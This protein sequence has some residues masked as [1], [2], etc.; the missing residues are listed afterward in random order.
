M[1]LT[2]T[3][4][5][6]E[7]PSYHKEKVTQEASGRVYIGKGSTVMN[8]WVKGHSLQRVGKSEQRDQAPSQRVQNKEP[9]GWP[10]EPNEP[11]REGRGQPRARRGAQ[12][13]GGYLGKGSVSRAKLPFIT[14]GLSF[15]GSRPPRNPPQKHTAAEIFLGLA[16]WYCPQNTMGGSGKRPWASLL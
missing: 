4:H 1:F 9:K 15:V 16:S 8:P 6:D 3:C 10:E 7:Q 11:W 13:G 2:F 5:S 12:A 14:E